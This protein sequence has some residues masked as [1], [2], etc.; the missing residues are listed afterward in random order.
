MIDHN[1]VLLKV[2]EILM[3]MK[4]ITLVGINMINVNLKHKN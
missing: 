1:A 3:E 2:L 4:H